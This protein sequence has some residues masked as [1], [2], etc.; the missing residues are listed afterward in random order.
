MSTVTTLIQASEVVNGGIM[1]ATPLNNR[2]DAS[3]LSDVIHLAEDAFL[4]PFICADFYA[5]LLAEKNATASNYNADLGAIV[6]AFPTNANYETLWTQ[7]LYPYLARAVYY[8]ALPNITLQTGSN[9]L[10]ASD[11][12]FGTNSGLE[13]LKFMADTQL[14]YLKARRPVIENY[15]C[16]NTALFPL[17]CTD[18]ICKDNC[19]GTSESTSQGPDLGLIFY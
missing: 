6:Q 9:G 17:F 7:Y 13:G 2:F 8:M 18:D 4:K 15:L 16:N 5:D 19:D 14:S 1:K 10:F 3:R 12:Q 11:S